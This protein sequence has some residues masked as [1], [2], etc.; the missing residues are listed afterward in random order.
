MTVLVGTWGELAEVAGSALG[1]ASWD[2]G[3]GTRK[4]WNRVF[5]SLRR[6]EGRRSSAPQAK[7]SVISPSCVPL[8]RG[9]AGF[10]L[11]LAHRAR[12]PAAGVSCSSGLNSGTYSEA[13]EVPFL[14]ACCV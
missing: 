11:F 13:F 6:T 14:S 2:G 10:P 9:S 8:S 3:V 1:T 5:L 4:R 12:G 7:E